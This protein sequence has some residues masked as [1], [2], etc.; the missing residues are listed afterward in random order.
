VVVDKPSSG[1]L[2]SAEADFRDTCASRLL[3]QLNL[4]ELHPAQTLDRSASGALLFT[5]NPQQLELE[6]HYLAVVRGFVSSSE[7]VRCLEQYSL[8][9]RV[10]PYSTCRYSLIRVRGRS[11]ETHHI[12]RL[13]KNLGH[14]I[15]G[16]TRHGDNAHNR[17]MAQLLEWNRLALASVEVRWDA[18]LVS[19][20]LAWRMQ[21]MIER[22]RSLSGARL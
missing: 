16:D 3:R 17:W 1:L 14:P 10:G 9:F 8:P 11:R 19:C 12:R 5:T 21:A 6:E 2:V 22:L 4:A 20:P 13:L 15:V 7:G 18:K